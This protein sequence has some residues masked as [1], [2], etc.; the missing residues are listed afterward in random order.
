MSLEVANTKARCTK[1][2]YL[3]GNRFG[4]EETLENITV[5]GLLSRLNWKVPNIPFEALEARLNS[6]HP[7]GQCGRIPRLED[8]KM[9]NYV[10]Q[11]FDQP[12]ITIFL[13]SAHLDMRE[14]N[15]EPCVRIFATMSRPEINQTSYPFC[16]I[17]TQGSDEPVSV[18]ATNFRFTGWEG[19]WNKTDTSIMT[20][21][22]MFDCLLPT[23]NR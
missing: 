9:N 14:N 7:S 16:Q 18:R 23:N 4:E 11:R 13:Y 12:D 21:P 8:L 19:I 1:T 2:M 17:W 10:W 22:H 20:T 3:E 6:S 5:S 15:P